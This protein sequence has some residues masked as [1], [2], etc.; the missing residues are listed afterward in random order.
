M[1]DVHPNILLLNRLYLHDLEGS[2]DLFA[3]GFVWHYFNPHLPELQGDYA[4]L[5]ELQTFFKRLHAK[6]DGTFNVK[7]ISATAYGNEL[8][9][10]HTQNTLTLQDQ[11][12]T[13]DVVVVWRIVDGQIAEAWDIPSVHTMAIPVDQA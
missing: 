7:P 4:G 12:I 1:A 3:Q 13:I 9:V 5:S 10:T 6:S 11:P 8:V 2:A